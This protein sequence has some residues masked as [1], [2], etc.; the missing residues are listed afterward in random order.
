MHT[1]G[2]RPSLTCSLSVG[3]I[4]PSWV[5]TGALNQNGLLYQQLL[6]GCFLTCSSCSHTD[7]VIS[8]CYQLLLSRWGIMNAGVAQYNPSLGALPM[9][10]CDVCHHVCNKEYL[11]VGFQ[12]FH[13]STWKATEIS[14]VSR[15]GKQAKSSLNIIQIRGRQPSHLLMRPLVE[16]ILFR[17]SLVRAELCFPTNVLN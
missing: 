3:C 1:G 7:A 5:W 13:R 4:H 14:R 8:S 17:R 2:T 15:K 12:P 9:I 11:L 10:H 16:I 6:P